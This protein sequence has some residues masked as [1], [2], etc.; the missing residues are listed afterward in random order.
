MLLAHTWS[1]RM[2]CLDGARKRAW[3]PVRCQGRWSSICVTVSKGRRETSMQEGCRVPP[4]IGCAPLV[5][6][7]AMRY[8]FSFPVLPLLR[9]PAARSG[10][11]RAMVPDDSHPSRHG[12][13][14]RAARRGTAHVHLRKY[15]QRRSCLRVASWRPCSSS[16]SSRALQQQVAL[17]IASLVPF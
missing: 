12:T 7:A 13:R 17:L 6:D 16:Y 3:K 1:A 10:S 11:R 4:G 9:D 14:Q 15:P 8:V 5:L 2:R